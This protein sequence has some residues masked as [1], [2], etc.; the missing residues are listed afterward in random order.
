MEGQ[1]VAAIRRLVLSVSV[2]PFLQHP[3][4]LSQAAND[5]PLQPRGN[6][7]SRGL[8]TEESATP[9]GSSGPQGASW[10]SLFPAFV[11]MVGNLVLP[12]EVMFLE[13]AASLGCRP[14]G[15]L[16]RSPWS[17]FSRPK[18]SVCSFQHRPLSPSFGPQRVICGK[19]WRL[20]NCTQAKSTGVPSALSLR[21]GREWS[22]WEV[23]GRHRFLQASPGCPS[24]PG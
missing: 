4:S 24:L 21:S 17:C 9:V 12:N 1:A 10:G 23:G 3:L 6:R 5:A 19:N 8:A 16:P 22:C 20:G 15:C 2:A 11:E 13:S 14:A 7:G 18:L